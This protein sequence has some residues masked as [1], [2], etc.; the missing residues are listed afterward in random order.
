[1]RAL[2]VVILVTLATIVNAQKIEFEGY[3]SRNDGLKEFKDEKSRLD[4]DLTE[5]TVTFVS[6]GGV[7]LQFPISEVFKKDKTK[8]SSYTIVSSS[9]Q[10]LILYIP[11]NE[12]FCIVS[13]GT[14]IYSGII[15]NTTE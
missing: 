11:S 15:I 7:F 13:V 10:E 5:R 9:G 12:E 6:Q 3:H 14:R 4:I 2:L 1:M 8:Y